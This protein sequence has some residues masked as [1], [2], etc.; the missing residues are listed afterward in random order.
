M[1]KLDRWTRAEPIP[2]AV[3]HAVAVAVAVA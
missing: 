3:N 1:I 2:D